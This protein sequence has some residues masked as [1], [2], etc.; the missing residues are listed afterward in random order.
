MCSRRRIWFTAMTLAIA[1]VIW[2]LFWGLS[3]SE[4]VYKG[5]RLSYWLQGYNAQLRHLAGPQRKDTEEAIRQIGTNGIPTM[6]KMLQ[7]K[8]SWLKTKWITL[9]RKQHFVKADVINATD[10][11]YSAS[12]ALLLLGDAASNAVPDLIEIYDKNISHFSKTETC[13]VLGQLGPLARQ[14]IP[15]LIRNMTND[16]FYVRQ[17]AGLALDRIHLEPKLVVPAMIAALHDPA[18]NLVGNAVVTLGDYGPDA[19]A[20]IPA[21]LEL[22]KTS[23]AGL[24]EQ[25]KTALRSI[26]R[27]TADQAGMR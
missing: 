19:K 24:K 26:D 16:D 8:D 27:E 14:A 23:D 15:S 11:N 3:D 20:A 7:A 5:K 12:S 10:K 25:I 2:W 4:P 9:V 21:L 17:D 22:S 6:L 1:G 18:P 13:G